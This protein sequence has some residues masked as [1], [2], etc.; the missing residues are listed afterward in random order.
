MNFFKVVSVILVAAFCMVVTHGDAQAEGRA[1]EV[2]PGIYGITTIGF[3]NVGFIVTEKGV[4]VVDTQMMPD[5]AK[6]L[7]KEIKAVTDKP[8]KYAI[9]THWHTDHV[10]GNEVFAAE[11]VP[12]IAHDFTRKKVAERRKEQDEGKADESMAMLGDLK[13]TPPDISFDTNMILDMGDKVIE[14]KFLGGGHTSGD[15]VV[16]L[17]KEKV[18]FSG[19]L[20]M[21][22]GLPDYRDDA[23]I[24]NHIASQKKMQAMDIG[25]I[26]CGHQDILEKKDIQ[27]STNKLIAFRKQVKA[28]VDKNIPVE[29][30]EEE[31]KFPEGENPFYEARFKPMIR[32]VYNDLKAAK[33]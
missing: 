29:K 24:D 16:Y 17:P 23:S 9:N 20:F 26:V 8:I 27:V 2:G 19:D 33:K 1:I 10:G 30:A 15:I 6:E 5:L 7:I 12:I 18:L 14:L 3:S 32:K 28:Y 4:V 11:G 31:I 13:L 22:S 25:K 21:K